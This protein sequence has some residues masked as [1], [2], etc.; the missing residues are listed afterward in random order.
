MH[1]HGI[2]VDVIVGSKTKDLLILEEEMEN[3]SRKS[4]RHH[5]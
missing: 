5:R 3:G 4:L 1:E 2:D